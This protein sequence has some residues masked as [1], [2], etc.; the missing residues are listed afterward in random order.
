MRPVPDRPWLPELELLRDDA[1][2]RQTEKA[3]LV[4]ETVNE[5]GGAAQ[6]HRPVV[7]RGDF[8]GDVGGADAAA[9]G[10]EPEVIIDIRVRDQVSVAEFPIIDGVARV[11]GD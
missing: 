1:L 8:G 9:L 3:K 2:S 6:H 11:A 10:R 5:L 4:G 7:E